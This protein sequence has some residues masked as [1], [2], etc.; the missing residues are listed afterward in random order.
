ML[1]VLTCIDARLDPLAILGLEIGEAA[2]IRTPGARVT[3]ETLATLVLARWVLGVERVL[4]VAHT[5]C[6]VA[7][8]S[9]DDI[10]AAIREAGGPDTSA[11]RFSV[12]PDEDADLAADVERLR[13]ELGVT[14]EGYVYDVHTG[15]LS[16]GGR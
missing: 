16:P 5:D 13:G 14:V 11:L 8:R 4:V 10:R 3:D 15:E 7:G 1:A 6:R 2:I 12:A 9:E